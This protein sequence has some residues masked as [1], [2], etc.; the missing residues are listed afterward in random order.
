MS[1]IIG[2]ALSFIVI[3]RILEVND[4]SGSDERTIAFTLV[5]IAN[6]SVLISIVRRSDISQLKVVAITV[7]LIAFVIVLG[8]ISVIVPDSS[9]YTSIAMA[10]AAWIVPPTFAGL[11]V[12]NR[13]E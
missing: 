9:I 4:S 3:L 13:R 2:F 8:A 12:G 1:L 5:L 11:F 6:L 10:F 7:V